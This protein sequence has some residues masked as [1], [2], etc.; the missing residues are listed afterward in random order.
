MEGLITAACIIYLI[1]YYW[2]RKHI[3]K[4]LKLEEPAFTVDN[5]G[6]EKYFMCSWQFTGGK[7][8]LELLNVRDKEIKPLVQDGEYVRRGRKVVEVKGNIKPAGERP[9]YVSVYV[10]TMSKGYFYYI[11]DAPSYVYERKALFVIEKEIRK[12]KEGIAEAKYQ[13]EQRKIEEW[14]KIKIAKW[15]ESVES[16]GNDVVISSDLFDEENKKKFDPDK[17]HFYMKYAEGVHDCMFLNKGDVIGT[18]CGWYRDDYGIEVLAHRDG[19]VYYGGDSVRVNGIVC[20]LYDS[21]EDIVRWEFERKINVIEQVDEFTGNKTLKTEEEIK[22]SGIT[23]CMFQ[24]SVGSAS[25]RF[26]YETGTINLVKNDSLDFLFEDRVLQFTVKSSPIRSASEPKKRICDIIL[27]KEELGV[28]A[29]SKLLKVR[30]K[31]KDVDTIDYAVRS[32]H[33]SEEMTSEI[34]KMAA[35]NFKR[36]IEELGLDQVEKEP[37]EVRDDTCY[38]YIMR[39][40]A[41]NCHKIGISNRPEYR[42]KTLQSDKPYITLLQAKEF[43][44]R[45]IAKAFESALHKTYESKHMRGEWF[46]LSQEEVDEVISSLK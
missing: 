13:E 41:N 23:A 1:Y 18:L 16:F 36:K 37:Q 31:T 40:E 11:G 35:D 9:K 14:N 34:V 3:K 5:Y 39:D 45:K 29:S 15:P 38:V 7:K 30:I 42:E 20:R 8:E 12:N 24:Y 46:D 6:T 32:A 17:D 26:E 2:R 19:Y 27:N 43:P 10:K 4:S 25:L 44:S 21:I 22:L 28:F 33:C